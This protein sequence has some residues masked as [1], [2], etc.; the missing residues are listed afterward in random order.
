MS[1]QDKNL[2]A[3]PHKKRDKKYNPTKFKTGVK[4][5]AKSLEDVNSKIAVV[6]AEAKAI[7]DKW[8]IYETEFKEAVGELLKGAGIWDQV[9]ALETEREEIRKQADEKFKACEVRFQQL[10][11]V[12]GYFL[13]GAPTATVE[14]APEIEGEP[15][16]K[17]EVPAAE[18]AEQMAEI[19]QMKAKEPEVSE[20]VAEE[21]P[22]AAAAV[23]SKVKRPVPPMF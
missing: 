19:I 4:M 20:P 2:R 7:K 10:Q 12:K 17:E 14:Q 16:A 23:A 15:A 3:R 22:V 18:V 8:Q 11:T 13:E 21:A 9:N 1:R 6:Q 5:S